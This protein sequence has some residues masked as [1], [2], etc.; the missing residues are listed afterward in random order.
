MSK[1]TTQLLRLLGELGESIKFCTWGSRDPVLPGLEVEGVGEVGLPMTASAAQQLIQH[2]SAAPYGRGEETVLDPQ[3]RRVWQIEPRQFTFRN[4]E[5]EKLI[6][7]IVDSVKGELGIHHRVQSDLYK[8]LI[9]EK[10]SFFIPHRDTEKVEGM[11]GTLVVCLP[12]RYRGGELLVTHEGQTEAIDFGGPQGEFRIHYAAFYADCLHEIKPVTEGYRVCLVYNLALAG[13]KTQPAP[14]EGSQPVRRAAALL[15]QIFA[16]DSCSKIAIPLQHEYTEAGLSFDALKGQD[17]ARVDALR[18]AAQ[19]A[20]CRMYLALLEYYQTGAADYDSYSY[21]RYGYDEEDD[22]EVEMYEVFDE[23]LTLRHL[24]DA[25][26]RRAS[27]ERLNIEKD[28]V[29]SEKPFEELPFKQEVSE[30]T[31]NEGATVERWYRQAMVVLWPE[32]RFT[33]VLAQEGPQVAVPALAEMVAASQDPAHDPECRRFAAEILGAWRGTSSQYG[34]RESSKSPEMLKQLE[35]IADATLVRRFLK[36]VLVQD[37]S[38]G[39]GEI[40]ARIAAALGW[41]TFASELAQFVSAQSATDYS[42]SLDA[43][44]GIVKDLCCSGGAMTPERRDTCRNVAA[45]LID[46]IQQWGARRATYSWSNAKTAR[47]ETVLAVFQSLEA[48]DAADLLDEFVSHMLA[49]PKNYDL[50]A[51]LIPAIRGVHASLKKKSAAAGAL[52]R[53]LDHA[54]HELE[55]RTATS[56]EAPKDWAQ[57]VKIKCNCADCNELEKFLRDPQERVHRFRR[58]EPQRTHLE[59]TV[60]QY[61]CDVDCVTER[62]GRPYTLVITKNRASYERRTKQFA[63]DQEL[64]TELRRIAGRKAK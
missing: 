28:D 31:G 33:R 6:G 16:D 59:T 7:D 47:N 44:I 14:P 5:W 25:S 30:A 17:R 49:H 37:Y 43:T 27:F 18:L 48:I 39:E 56:V 20:G 64:L 3:V 1:P 45:K 35:R 4:P 12:S 62:T 11:F 22:D 63:E 50:H 52:R 15:K 53:L 23:D 10:G 57:L 51:V 13:R 54:M 8:L 61:R 29:L 60:E 40:L 58:A 46:K 36:S 32:D 55:S 26:G 2:A 42:A 24:I 9:Y 38:G 21:S 41:K 19:Q 34:K